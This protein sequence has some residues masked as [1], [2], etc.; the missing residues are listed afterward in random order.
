[1]AQSLIDLMNSLLLPLMKRD[2][3]EFKAF[4]HAVNSY[5]RGDKDEMIEDL[6]SLADSTN[7]SIARI[8]TE[9]IERAQLE[10]F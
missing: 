9:L 8:A 10:N 6:N 3:P 2:I 5:V 7:H 4:N 1:M